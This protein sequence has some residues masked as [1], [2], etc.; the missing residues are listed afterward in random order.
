ME[1][2]AV[3]GLGLAKL[4]EVEAGLW[5]ILQ[6]NTIQ[7]QGVHCTARVLTLLK[8]S[9]MALMQVNLGAQYKSRYTVLQSETIL[10]VHGIHTSSAG[11][12]C[13]PSGTGPQSSHPGLSQS[14]QTF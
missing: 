11:T 14:P 4:Q 7:G 13:T 9:I 2:T 6:V 1:E 8:G 3:V 10:Q 12:R 5:P